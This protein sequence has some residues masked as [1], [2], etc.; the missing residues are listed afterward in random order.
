MIERLGQLVD[1]P[2]SGEALVKVA[3][4]DKRSQGSHQHVEPDDGVVTLVYGK[5]QISHLT[6]CPDDTGESRKVISFHL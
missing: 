6:I 4:E 1:E 3:Y 5:E 2:L